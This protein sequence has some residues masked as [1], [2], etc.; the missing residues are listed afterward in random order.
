MR[1]PSAR[2]AAPSTLA[3]GSLGVGYRAAHREALL[4]EVLPAEIQH[5]EII[6]EN[7]LGPAPAPRETLRRLAARL[8]IVLHGVGLNLLGA[9]PLDE[10]YLDAVARLA[11]E[12]D[13]PFV[14]D[15]LCWTGS[16]G[17]AH[18]DLLPFPYTDEALELAAARAAHV[19]ARLGRPFGLENVS[20][21]V[22][23]VESRMSEA[24]FTTRVVREAGCWLMF[25]VNNAVVSAHDHGGDPE[26][27]LGL[28]DFSRVLQV[29]VA[30]HDRQADGLWVDTHD[31]EA[32]DE[33][34]ALYRAAWRAGG[35]F[36]TLFEWDERIP[37]L[38]VVVEQ[39]RRLVEAR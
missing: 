19:Q 10:R 24:E 2:P 25:D 27:W 39:L 32:S 21:Y 34:R 14:T 38:D 15:H 22:T 29:H 33:T 20:S 18:F 26:E 36:P 1:Q 23:F 11:D 31:R 37:P 7:F 6:T 12:V 17:H 28:V 9:E 5:L 13:A 4:G 3:R 8:P 30:G 35:P 16:A